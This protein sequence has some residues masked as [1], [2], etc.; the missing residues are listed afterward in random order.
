MWDLAA[1]T[2]V[3]NLEL[4]NVSIVT[5]TTHSTCWC[6]VKQHRWSTDTD[7]PSFHFEMKNTPRL[8]LPM[9]HKKWADTHTTTCSIWVHNRPQKIQ[10]FHGS[11]WHRFLHRHNS[12]DILSLTGSVREGLVCGW[13]QA[14]FSVFCEVFAGKSGSATLLRH[15]LKVMEPS[16]TWYTLTLSFSTLTFTLQ[17]SDMGTS[18]T[19]RVG[20]PFQAEF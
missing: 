17:T 5:H 15:V 10:W 4:V 16:S 20:C 14:S 11:W 18:V 8:P 6:R 7:E 19:R 13:R 12:L 3:F 9:S 2:P 1:Y